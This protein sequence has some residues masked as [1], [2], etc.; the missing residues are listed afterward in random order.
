MSQDP[1]RG[2]RALAYVLTA[3][4]LLAAHGATLA[5][6]TYARTGLSVSSIQAPNPAL[7]WG[8]TT[9]GSV[10]QSDQLHRVQ[11]AHVIESYGYS[12]LANLYAGGY[13]NA[14]AFAWA[15]PGAVGASAA[16]EVQARTVPNGDSGG[17][18]TAAAKAYFTD[19]ITFTAP[20]QIPGRLLKVSGA[21]LLTGFTFSD[22]AQVNIWGAG[23][24]LST[25]N[26]NGW[27]L[28]CGGNTC[29]Y[30]DP[31]TNRFDW[32]S[33][34]PLLIPYTFFVQNGQAA[35]VEYGMDISIS[36]FVHFGP[37]ATDPVLC[38]RV[39]DKRGR[40][41]FGHTLA[42]G[43]ATVTTEYGGPVGAFTATGF[44]GFDYS[45][46]YAP[47]PEPAAWALMLAGLMFV[48]RRGARGAG[49]AA[50]G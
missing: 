18:G 50:Q 25:W 15:E 4:S 13:A 14:N 3:A 28:S 17:Q 20:S 31:N 35:R 38:G 21:L 45:Q 1:D 16:V 33:G 10:D 26:P 29:V 46:P 24:G 44:T 5:Q 7:Q 41:D 11:S 36:A 32:T 12:L 2:A 23:T 42:W 47:V 48:R 37:C 40:A 22:G 43:G 39:D 34:T 9:G 49:A 27:R 6:E 30:T 8:G 19:M